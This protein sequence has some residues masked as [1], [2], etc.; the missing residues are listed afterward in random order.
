MRLRPALL[1]AFTAAVAAP[2][3]LATSGLEYLLM[4]PACVVGMDDDATIRTCGEKHATLR[5]PLRAA[6]DGWK[7]RNAAALQEMSAHCQGGLATLYRELGIG[8]DGVERVRK[9]ALRI[10]ELARQEL[11]QGSQGESR[12]LDMARRFERH[13][14]TREELEQTRR[15]PLSLAFMEHLDPDFLRE[16]PPGVQANYQ[17]DRKLHFAR[18][19]GR[20]AALRAGY[21]SLGANCLTYTV[22]SCQR[23]HGTTIGVAGDLLRRE[24]LPSGDERVTYAGAKTLFRGTFADNHP[25]GREERIFVLGR[26]GRIKDAWDRVQ[27][28]QKPGA[29]PDLPPTY[30]Y[31]CEPFGR[32]RSAFCNVRSVEP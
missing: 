13:S 31:S 24:R 19:H 28:L 15:I 6:H 11:E 17:R 30:A 12:C 22:E 9:A 26:D 10:F 21:A 16:P 20:F 8:P 5:E 1:A 25:A 4:T 32:S 18:S 3:A 7:S 14:I 23:A 27:L 29:P 2:P